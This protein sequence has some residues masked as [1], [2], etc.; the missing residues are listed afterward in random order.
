MSRQHD[1]YTTKRLRCSYNFDHLVDWPMQIDRSS[2]KT[3]LL[4]HFLYGKICVLVY[5]L[6]P[7]KLVLAH[8]S[9]RTKMRSSGFKSLGIIFN[10]FV[11]FQIADTYKRL[12]IWIHAIDFI[13]VS[14]KAKG[15][16]AGLTYGTV[17]CRWLSCNGIPL[18]LT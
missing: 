4:E 10:S 15:Q 13:D 6:M 5:F 2:T 16:I 18:H 1:K 9:T 14:Y 17:K 12:F 8:A 3:K 11:N 7:L